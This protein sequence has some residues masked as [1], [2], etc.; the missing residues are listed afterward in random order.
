M[1][2]WND[3]TDMSKE[4]DILTLPDHLC[5]WKQNRDVCIDNCISKTIQ[6]LWDH[7]IETL[8]CCCGHGKPKMGGLT[9]IVESHYSDTFINSIALLLSQHDT[10]KWSILQ[11]RDN[12]LINTSK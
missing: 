12:K 2:E 6:I 7:N 5:T 3:K 8:G 1:C 11:W 4:P 10:R 9:V